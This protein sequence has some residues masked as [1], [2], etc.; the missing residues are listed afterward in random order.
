MI[1]ILTGA[2]IIL[3]FI[4]GVIKAFKKKEFTSSLMREGLF[5]KIGSIVVIVFAGLVDYAQGFMD[6]GISIP[7]TSTVCVYIV[8][9]EIGS[10]IEN[11]C[12]INPSII[13]TKLQAYFQKLN[14]EVKEADTVD[15]VHSKK[16]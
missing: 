7:L 13:P 15:E 5:H 8:L 2:F 1:Y 10:I 6:L 16:R 3:D 9:M 11:V 12:I 14:K 4:T